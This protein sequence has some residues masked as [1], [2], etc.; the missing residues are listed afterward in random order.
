MKFTMELEPNG[1]LPFLDVL[2]KKRWMAHWAT[3]YKGK[4]HPQ[5]NIYMWIHSIIRHKK[6]QSPPLSSTMH[7]LS[8]MK[9]VYRMDHL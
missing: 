3:R 5:T 2:I 7:E 9:T 4:P 6:E 1:T 8:V